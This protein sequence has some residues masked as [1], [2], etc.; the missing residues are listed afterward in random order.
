MMTEKN[1]SLVKRSY[2]LPPFLPGFFFGA[3]FL[4]AML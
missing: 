4:A 1:Q 2:F 3:F